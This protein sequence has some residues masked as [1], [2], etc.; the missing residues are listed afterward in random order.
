MFSFFCREIILF[1]LWRLYSL[2][3]NVGRY[4]V[5]K[6]HSVFQDDETSSEVV[7]L[8]ERILNM[9]LFVPFH[10]VV[11]ACCLRWECLLTLYLKATVYG[12]S[13]V[14]MHSVLPDDDMSNETVCLPRI[15]LDVAA[16]SNSLC[17]LIVVS[18]SV[19][20]DE[21]ICS[22]T[23]S[24]SNANEGCSPPAFSLVKSLANGWK[25]LAKFHK[26]CLCFVDLQVLSRHPIVDTR[27]AEICSFRP[28]L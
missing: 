24:M 2:A 9:D 4:C 18:H 22:I 1:I 5:V 26:V 3:K 28:Y 13:H 11:R 14:K 15:S 19:L 25:N 12:C 6:G 21:N 20:F 23:V 10:S 7:C 17:L 8:C 16:C 27:H